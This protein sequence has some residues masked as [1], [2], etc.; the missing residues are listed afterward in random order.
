MK[1]ESIIIILLSIVVPSLSWAQLSK[2]IGLYELIEIVHQD[3]KHMEAD[4]KQYKLCMKNNTLTIQYQP[5]VFSK[6]FD[7]F[8]SKPD[9]TPLQLTGELSKKKNKGTQVFEVSDNTFTLRWFNESSDNDE[10]LFPLNTNIDEKYR[11]VNDTS[12]VMLHACNLLQMKLGAKRHRL[13]GCWKLRGKQSANTATSQYWIEKDDSDQYI[14]FGSGSAVIIYNNNDFPQTRLQGHFTTCR[15]LSEYAIDLDGATSII[16]WFDNATISMTTIDHSGHPSVTVWDRC[17]LPQNVQDVFDTD[18]PQMKKDITRFFVE[19]F[20]KKY[21][22]LPNSVRLAFE[23]FDFAIDAIEKNHACFPILMRSGF[24]NEYNGM[25]D[26][27]K[28]QLLK[29]EI[30]IDEAVGHYIYWFFKNFDRHTT[31]TSNTFYQLM[32]EGFVYYP[33]IMD[34]YQPEPVGCKVDN[35]TYLLRLPSCFGMVP[36]MEWLQKKKEEFLQS[37]CPY[38]ILDLRGNTGGSDEYSLLFTELMCDSP[39]SEEHRAFYLNSTTNNKMLKKMCEASPESY[40]DAVL[41]ATETSE[42]GQLIDWGE[43][44]TAGTGE[45][46][47]KVRKGAIII[48]NF[49]ASAGESP[50][51][52]VRLYSRNHALVYGRERT[53]GADLSGNCNFIQ[54]PNSD[55]SIMYPMTVDAKFE[56]ACKN[57]A[58]GHKPDVI[59]P[60]PYPKQVTD[61]I[62]EWVLWVAKDLKKRT[63]HVE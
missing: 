31:C 3:G 39:S 41:A 48:D 63:E 1:K 42:E 51:R 32:P 5:V 22:N 52:M 57:R 14:I 36:T 2:P 28:A 16:N 19:G 33:E 25:K 30:S 13:Q 17:G 12:E 45:Y 4:Y 26:R 60:L 24:E 35:E 15:F 6:S 56:K 58:P 47:P 9:A 18:M 29:T 62:D 44:T 23:T 10:S 43:A 54:L 8:I 7:F 50:V 40:Q 20:T 11:L 55:I 53:W 34:H 21:G 49:T 59:I 38:L 27:L 61:N 37:G 46:T